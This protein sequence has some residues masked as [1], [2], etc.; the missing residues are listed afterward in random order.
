M[1]W[2]SYGNVKCHSILPAWPPSKHDYPTPP[3]WQTCKRLPPVPKTSPPAFWPPS[4]LPLVL[5]T[6]AISGKTE[7]WKGRIS[8]KPSCSP[9]MLQS[10]GP[11]LID[12][13]C[14]DMLSDG[15]ESD[16][17]LAMPDTGAGWGSKGTSWRVAALEPYLLLRVHLPVQYLSSLHIN[18]FH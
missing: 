13:Q 16:A 9:Q 6:L 11:A 17:P 2:S 18:C 15:E 14:L 10:I 12:R 5:P 8:K 7:K 4:L 1:L 3:G